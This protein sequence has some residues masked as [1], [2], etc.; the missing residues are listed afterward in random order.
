MTQ[1]PTYAPGT[2]VW[3]DLGSP[4]PQASSRFYGELFGWQ[5]QDLGEEAGH[6]TMFSQDGKR[7]AA[8]GPLQNP[9]QPPAWSTYVSTTDAAETARK[10]REAGGTVLVGPFPGVE[11][12]TLA[13]FAR[14]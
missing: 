2:P 9:N 5:S 10:V 3:V 6:Y 12:G 11:E 4:D 14:P 8:V 13:V 1:A 7:V